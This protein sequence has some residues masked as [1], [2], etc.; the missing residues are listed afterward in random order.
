MSLKCTEC[1]REFSVKSNLTRHLRMVHAVDVERIDILPGDFDT[2]HYKCLEGCNISFKYN[3]ELRRHL[4]A[5]HEMNMVEL[6]LDFPNS[7]EFKKWLHNEETENYVQYVHL[8]ATKRR[9]TGAETYYYECSRTGK[10]SYV[11]DT[12]RK[13]RARKSVTKLNR[14]CTSQIIVN[15]SHDGTLSVNY[16]K[17]HYGHEVDL[18]HVKL[19]KQDRGSIATKLLL[20]LPVTSVL[21]SVKKASGNLKRINLLGRKD[22]VN[23]RKS[24]N[25]D[26]KDGKILSV[27]KINVNQFL[28]ECNTCE[29]NPVLYCSIEEFPESN[30]LSY[31]LMTKHQSDMLKEIGNNIVVVNSTSLNNC[32]FEL[33]TLFVIGK[34]WES[35]PAAC[36]FTNKVHD[37]TYNLFFNKIKD[38][39]GV[40]APSIL[41]TNCDEMYYEAWKCVMGEVACNYYNP[42]QVE[43]D[44]KLNLNRIVCT[45]TDVTRV[46]RKWVYDSLKIF[47]NITDETE[48][49]E[50]LDDTMKVL[51]SDDDFKDFLEYFLKSYSDPKNWATCYRNGSDLPLKQLEVINDVLRQYLNE[52]LETRFDIIF[53][54][55]IRFIRDETVNSMLKTKTNRVFFVSEND[56]RHALLMEKRLS[57]NHLSDNVWSVTEEESR[58]SHIVQKYLEKKCCNLICTTCRICLH[59]FSCS[60]VDFFIGNAMCVHIHYI[61]VTYFKSTVQLSDDISVTCDEEIIIEVDQECEESVED[62]E[63]LRNAI[64]D[65]TAVLNNNIPNVQDV[66]TLQV[67]LETVNQLCD[68]TH[69][70][71]QEQGT[72]HLSD[73][74]Y[75]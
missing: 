68:L 60:C 18:E 34:S 33:I 48:F 21:H 51:S 71:D 52:D 70:E 64:A 55:L 5:K 47:Q 24:F 61:W 50:N 43:V 10:R 27:D 15:K 22:I 23:I 74:S 38:R 54:S 26:L 40:I 17:N 41:I 62:I 2:Y 19:S 58:I 31:I 72:E 28:T 39:V 49:V 35:F 1:S 73:H 65:R 53:H 57:G 25:I 75:L 36:M 14:G 59:C 42:I 11:D 6:N 63:V 29:Y 44:W 8:T 9:S 12:T 16:F 56:T 7:T 4:N 67:I 37:G 32:D 20:G 3:R 46:K 69:I 30:N 13:R 66:K 45:E